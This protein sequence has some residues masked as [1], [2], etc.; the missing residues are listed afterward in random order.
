MA[1]LERWVAELRAAEAVLAGERMHPTASRRVARR[2]AA[3][4]RERRSWR[5]Y[6]PAACFAAGALLVLLVL[7]V[8]PRRWHAEATP[9][10][11]QSELQSTAPSCADASATAGSRDDAPSC[12]PSPAS[13]APAQPPAREPTA[14]D[15]P[16]SVLAPRDPPR[17]AAPQRRA[18]S[19]R[20]PVQVPEPSAVVPS[21]VTEEDRIG[22]L[23]RELRSLRRAGRYA[24]AAR[25]LEDAL[26][27]TWPARTREVLHYEL[28]TIVDGHL[29]ASERACAHWR[30]HLERF[31]GT[32]YRRAVSDAQRRRGCALEAAPP[33]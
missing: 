10:A 18:E 12:E 30:E 6:L 25:R 23:L 28:G 13:T 8:N 24:D 7:A 3:G 20:N 21:P 27:E 32:R 15:E 14:D 2:L 4:E 1:D 16:S 17:A 26:G 29:D 5:P 11:S 31:P 22:A 9:R 19:F 33:E